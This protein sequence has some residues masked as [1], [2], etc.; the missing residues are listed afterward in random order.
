MLRAALATALTGAEAFFTGAVAFLTGAT[1]LLLEVL[2]GTGAAFLMGLAGAADLI[3]LIDALTGAAFTGDA[4]LA[5]RA[6]TTGEDFPALFSRVAFLASALAS[7]FLTATGAVGAAGAAALLDDLPRS[8][9]TTAFLGA[10]FFTTGAGLAAYFFTGTIALGGAT[11]LLLLSLTG[12]LA[13]TAL[14]AALTGDLGSGACT[15]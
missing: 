15:F 5:G 14:G 2:S 7:R 1:D 12:L 10:S 4:F 13:T 8:S 6:V 3:G 9:T 11:L